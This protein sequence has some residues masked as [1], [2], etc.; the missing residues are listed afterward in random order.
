MGSAT[1]VVPMDEDRASKRAASSPGSQKSSSSP[2]SSEKQ[3]KKPRTGRVMPRRLQL[4]T[5]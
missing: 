5:S 4:E 2:D 3:G 1:H